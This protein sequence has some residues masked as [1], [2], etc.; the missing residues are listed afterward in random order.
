MDLLH[1]LSESHALYSLS[2]L[3]HSPLRLPLLHNG[4]PLPGLAVD[5]FAV[6]AIGTIHASHAIPTTYTIDTVPTI[7]TIVAV[8]TIHAVAVAGASRVGTVTVA[9]I[10]GG[11][12]D[13]DH[14]TEGAGGGKERVE[15]GHLDGFAWMR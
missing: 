11:E 8:S 2:T 5:P 4:V 10:G 6:P 1:V 3:L 13:T 15:E 14:T 7:A 12:I 9:R